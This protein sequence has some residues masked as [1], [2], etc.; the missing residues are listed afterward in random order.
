LSTTVNHNIVT[1]LIENC[2]NESEIDKKVL[3]LYRINS[4]LPAVFRINIPSLI[5]DDYIDTALYGIEENI[6]GSGYH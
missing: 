1:K 3:I 4:L 6:R 5:T 2:Y